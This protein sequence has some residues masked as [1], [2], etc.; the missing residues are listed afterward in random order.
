LAGLL[1]SVGFTPT[2]ADH[3]PL[4]LG[5]IWLLA[6]TGFSLPRLFV[7]L[8]LYVI[9]FPFT[10]FLVFVYRKVLKGASPATNQQDA[11]LPNQ[12]RGFPLASLTISLRLGWLV[13]YGGSTSRGPNVVG[14]VIS[15][16]LFLTLAYRALDKTSPIDERDTIV[17][18]RW[19]VMGVL[20]TRNAS[21]SAIDN[22]PKTKF[23][24]DSGIRTTGLFMCPFRYV[25]KWFRG[26]RGRDKVAMMMLAEY[27]VFLVIL[28]VSAILFWALAMKAAP[29]EATL[30]LG[31]ALRISASQFFPRNALC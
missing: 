27:I 29:A 15:G 11:S 2:N 7:G 20:I 22:P 13:L 21:Q 26:R 1:S 12:P 3:L 5:G 10:V 25:T 31:A 17:F 24:V 23:L 4:V 16:I 28:A 30:S 18:S 14:C 9:F 19:A 8:P 6:I